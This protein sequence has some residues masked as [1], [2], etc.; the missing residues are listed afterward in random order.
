MWNVWAHYFRVRPGVP[1]LGFRLRDREG[2]DTI[3]PPS[4]LR[5]TNYH[6]DSTQYEEREE[7]DTRTGLVWLGYHEN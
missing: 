4:L 3:K 6:Y 7:T 5:S 1:P 2:T